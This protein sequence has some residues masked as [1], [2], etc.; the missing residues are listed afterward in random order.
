[1]KRDAFDRA[2]VNSPLHD[3]P[4][5]QRLASGSDFPLLFDLDRV[6]VRL[7]RCTRCRT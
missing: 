5:A 6:C 2:P 4:A 1:M 7:G 3:A